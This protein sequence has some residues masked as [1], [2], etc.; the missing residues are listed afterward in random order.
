MNW[1]PINGID[2]SATITRKNGLL[3][4]KLF[5]NMVN[6]NEDLKS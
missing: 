4:R 6:S 3:D 5:G 1:K 2:T